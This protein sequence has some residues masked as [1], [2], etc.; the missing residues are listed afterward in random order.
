MPHTFDILTQQLVHGRVDH[1]AGEVVAKRG[2]PWLDDLA[3]D[4][5]FK[6]LEND[7]T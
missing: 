4:I 6:L 1:E 3:I 7:E 2:I 5:Y